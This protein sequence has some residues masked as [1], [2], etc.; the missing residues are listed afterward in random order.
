[1][2]NA[3]LTYFDISTSRGEECRLALTLAG[4][5]FTDERLTGAQW[6]ARKASTPF[7]ALPVL[8]IE[9]HPPIAQSNAILRLIGNLKG[10][11]PADPFEAARHEA[12]M[13]V[14]EDFRARFSP[15]GKHKDPADKQRAREEFAQGYLPGWCAQ[16]ER[17]LGDPFVGGASI[18][19]ADLKLFVVLDPFLK[20]S[21]DH[22]SPDAFKAFPKLLR[23]V[24]AVK[25][26]PA[27]S[28]W[29]AR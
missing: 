11:H 24:E 3:T 14:V 13:G 16:I 4:M 20:G 8:T 5:P 25:R 26:H 27:I 23:Q 18:N 1:M 2:T 22:V 12:V 15:T 10:L 28:A 6:Q 9:G 19:V 7:G 29:Y 21:M 17:Q